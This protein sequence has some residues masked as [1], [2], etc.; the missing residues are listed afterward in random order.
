[1]SGKTSIK[2]IIQ[3]L[4]KSP[5]SSVM[6]VVGKVTKVDE[7]A[8]TCDIEPADGSAKIFAA[9]LQSSV[10]NAQGFVQIPK[11]GAFVVALPLTKEAFYV[12]LVDEVDKIL[13]DSPEV[14]INGGQNGAVF[15]SPEVI[16][17]LNKIVARQTAL[18]ALLIAFA[19]AQNSVAGGIPIFAPLIPAW[20]A[21]SAAIPGLP[22]NGVFNPSL[23]DEK[24]KH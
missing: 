12:V 23:T 4:A 3:D 9:R 11:N 1:M 14:I 2:E 13:I 21:L 7:G 10:D 19:S 6:P 16:I 8:R 22:P 17:E 18:E 15:N 24:L 20:A 5:G